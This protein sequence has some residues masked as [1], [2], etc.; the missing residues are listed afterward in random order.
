MSPAEKYGRP[1]DLP[2]A[3]MKQV[4]QIVQ[5]L[6]SNSVKQDAGVAQTPAAKYAAPASRQIERSLVQGRSL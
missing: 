5:T 2:P 1:Q 6:Q 4:E 3:A